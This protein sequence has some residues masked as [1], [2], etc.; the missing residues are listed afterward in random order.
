[1]TKTDSPQSDP[2]IATVQRM[3]EALGRGDIDA[4]VAEVA[5]DVDWI[6]VTPNGSPSVPWYGS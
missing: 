1:M 4:I 3:Y 2:K 6:S 5:D